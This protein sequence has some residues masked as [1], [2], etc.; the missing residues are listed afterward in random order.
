ME[1]NLKKELNNYN[2]SDLDEIKN[3][4][5]TKKF[6]ENNSNCFSRKNL[7]GH[8]TGSALII[9][10]EGNVLLNHHK[11]LDKWLIFGGHS[12][13]DS[14]SFNVA[15]RE[16]KEE[17]GITDFD[18]LDGK[19]FDI[20]VHKI[21]ENKSKNEPEHYH[22]D[23]RFLLIA[24][25][26]GFLVSNESTEIKWVSMQDVKKYTTDK[27]MNRMLKKVQKILK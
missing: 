27:S 25:N 5:L 11:L 12:D 14:N 10:K 4:E 13:G 2:P 18:E 1:F 26:K 19:I 21:P 23:I 3:L 8:I 16:A 17:T 24:K 9:D 6:L 22:Y 15:K 20:D 7:Q